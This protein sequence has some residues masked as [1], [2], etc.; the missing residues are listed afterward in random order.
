MTPPVHIIIFGPSEKF[1]SGISYYT[2]RLSNAL[3][4]KTDVT[5]ILFRHMLPEKLFPGWKRV[6]SKLTNLTFS[7]HVKTHEILDWYNPISWLRAYRIAKKGN[8]ILFEWWTSSI[9][10]MYLVIALLNLKRIPIIIEYHEV[11]DPIEQANKVLHG[12]SRC[13]GFFLRKLS[14]HFIVHSEADKRLIAHT[15]KI[16]DKRI[17]VIAH[18]LYDHYQQIDRNIAKSQLNVKEDFVILF[19]GLLRPYK[20]LKYLIK[21]FESLPESILQKSRLIIAGEPWEDQESLTLFNQSPVKS[22]ITLIGR[23]INDEEISVIFSSAHVLVIPYTR[24]SQSGVAHIGMRF[25]IPIIATR[26]GGLEESLEKYDGTIFIDPKSSDELKSALIRA[27]LNTINYNP[28]NELKWDVISNAWIG[29][30]N[31]ILKK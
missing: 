24:A 6:G 3:A 20:G 4:E 21:A 27:S 9:A 31:N 26:V 10:I 5:A 16:D 19:F 13:A 30:I 23:Y 14:A 15:Y 17:E 25:G 22:K 7:D 2:I 12:Y 11:V 8:I 18:G 28:P 29:S 1:L